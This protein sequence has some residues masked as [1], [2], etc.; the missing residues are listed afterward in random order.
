MSQIFEFEYL[1][2]QKNLEISWSKEFGSLPDRRITE[3]D[4]KG[5]LVIVNVQ[6]ED[7]GVYICTARNEY[8]TKTAQVEVEIGKYGFF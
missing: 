4:E 5:I 1:N 3:T 7:R 6:A 8:V 2:F